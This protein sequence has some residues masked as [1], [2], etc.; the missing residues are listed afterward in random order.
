MKTIQGA[1]VVR[2]EGRVPTQ[3]EEHFVQDGRVGPD[4]GKV[5]TVAGIG[6][7]VRIV[8]LEV[9]PKTCPVSLLVEHLLELRRP[10][11]LQYVADAWVQDRPLAAEESLSRLQTNAISHCTN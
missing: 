7:Q 4:V 5:A 9:F 10:A 1:D 2:G 11:G 6:E 3:A 8:L